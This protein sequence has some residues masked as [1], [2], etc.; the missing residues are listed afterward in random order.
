MRMD[1][2]HRRPP[3]SYCGVLDSYRHRYIYKFTQ[4]QMMCALVCVIDVILIGIWH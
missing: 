4:I 3:D 1:L 2:A